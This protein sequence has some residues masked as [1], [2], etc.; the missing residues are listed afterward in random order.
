MKL[1]SN[2]DVIS[3]F[4]VISLSCLF[5]TLQSQEYLIPHPMMYTTHQ[6]NAGYLIIL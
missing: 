2:D 3:T 6:S 1:I 4:F 5:S